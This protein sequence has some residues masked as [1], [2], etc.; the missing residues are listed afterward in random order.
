ML[1]DHL[2]RN[3]DNIVVETNMEW[4]R[5]LI[6]QVEDY[7]NDKAM[8]QLLMQKDDEAQRSIVKAKF[9]AVLKTISQ[10][11]QVCRALQSDDPQGLVM[12]TPPAIATWL[13]KYK[14]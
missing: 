6:L 4:I 3:N 9:T 2:E 5:L 11:L 1:P 14:L 12:P 13:A 8:H 7:L 10:R